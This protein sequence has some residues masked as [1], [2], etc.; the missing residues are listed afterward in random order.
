[1][2][3]EVE[4]SRA[5]LSSLESQVSSLTSGLN[6]AREAVNSATAALDR[7]RGRAGQKNKT[8]CWY[9]VCE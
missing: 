1:M 6:E 5:R 8:N 2:A 4:R 3:E 7:R 9:I